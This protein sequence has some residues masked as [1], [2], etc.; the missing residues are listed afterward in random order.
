[1]GG[2]GADIFY[3]EPEPKKISGAGAEAKCVGSATLCTGILFILLCYISH[4]L[5]LFFLI[6]P[7]AW[8]HGPSCVP[9]GCLPVSR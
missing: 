5:T 7:I 9:D 8:L 2:A 6:T 4:R 3:L 1:M